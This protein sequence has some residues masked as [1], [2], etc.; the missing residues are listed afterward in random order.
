MPGRDILPYVLDNQQDIGISQGRVCLAF[1]ARLVLL[2][3]VQ[4]LFCWGTCKTCFAEVSTVGCLPRTQL[5]DDTGSEPINAPA[6]EEP[7]R[8]SVLPC[9]QSTF[10]Y[11]ATPTPNRLLN[12]EQ[13][14]KKL[15]MAGNAVQVGAKQLHRQARVLAL[16]QAE[17][18]EL[19][20]AARAAA[21]D[22]PAPRSKHPNQ[23][24]QAKPACA[25]LGL[26]PEELSKEVQRLTVSIQGMHV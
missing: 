24:Q 17:I 5:A 13:L 15:Q 23:L 20:Q 22:A 11:K 12:V 18:A 4:Y 26:S 21:A 8:D 2:R 19:K 16:Q 25:G 3:Q 6:S 7:N 1:I 9:N 14:R 10:D